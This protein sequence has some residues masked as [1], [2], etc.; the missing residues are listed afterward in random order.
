MALFEQEMIS[1]GGLDHPGI[2]RAPDAGERNGHWYIIME[3]V[4]GM[5]CGALVRQHGTLP[6]RRV[7]RS[8]GRRRWRVAGLAVA[9][10]DFGHAD[11]RK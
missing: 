4:D 10:E 6:V 8:F 2:V 5:D 1:V 7:A 9:D 11:C 3:F